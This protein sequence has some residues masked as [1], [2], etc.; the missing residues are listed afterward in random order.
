P[1][2]G[3]ERSAAPRRV[4]VVDDNPDAAESLEMLL[5][6]LG[7]ETRVA[8]DG[9]AA[10]AAVRDFHPSIV[11]LDL[12]MP[13][14]DG[15]EVARRIRERPDELGRPLLI[16]LTGWGQPEDRRRT[17]EAGFDD[18]PVKPVDLGVLKSLLAVVDG[19]HAGGERPAGGPL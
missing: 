2:P 3:S 8:G 4:L 12:G 16:A 7:A 14:M 15:Y 18:H 19:G 13:G 17:R 6:V 11:L 9:E 5:R 10:L 1:A